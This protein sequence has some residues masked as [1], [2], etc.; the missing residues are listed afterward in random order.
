[1]NICLYT[2]LWTQESAS[3]AIHTGHWSLNISF[4][5]KINFDLESFAQDL[6]TCFV[7]KLRADAVVFFFEPLWSKIK[8]LSVLNAF[9]SPWVHNL[10]RFCHCRSSHMPVGFTLCRISSAGELQSFCGKAVKFGIFHE[11]VGFILGLIWSQHWVHISS[12]S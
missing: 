9:L 12:L 3:S 8:F 1:M 2:I 5:S 7:N 11:P 4:E 10:G 6:R